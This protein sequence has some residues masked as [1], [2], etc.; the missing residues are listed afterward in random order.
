[1]YSKSLSNRAARIL[2][3][4]LVGDLRLVSVCLIFQALGSACA[5]ISG[6]ISEYLLD[7]VP[8]A[9]HRLFVT[10]STYHANFG[11]LSG[12][13]SVCNTV[14]QSAGLVRAYRAVARDSS[15]TSYRDRF[16]GT[17]SVYMYSR[18]D[19][20][21]LIDE[22][23]PITPMR[24]LNLTEAGDAV[25]GVSWTGGGGGDTCQNWSSS[26]SLDVGSVGFVGANISVS[27]WSFSIDSC[28]K[29]FRLFCLSERREEGVWLF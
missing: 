16:S 18:T 3:R 19:G 28:D 26:S 2:E 4:L 1:V 20:A 9:S 21:V 23:F 13:D 27:W 7:G 11:G 22:S 29:P 5:Q 14:A 24:G 25:T 6:E 8:L 12:M 17:A 15:M 10:S